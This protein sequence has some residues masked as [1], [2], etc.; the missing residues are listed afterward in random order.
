D[1]LTNNNK[2]IRDLLIEC[3]D[4]LDRNEFTCP[5]IDPNAAVPSS[6]VV[7]Y[8]CGLKMFK[9]LAY[10]FR[11]HMKQ[12]DVFPVIMRNRDNCYY[13]RKCRTQYTKIGH[14]QKLN[15]ACEQTKF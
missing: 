2:T 15:H 10:Q 6:K 8:K 12:D 14:A 4:R 7:C 1:Y 5:G 9:E 11:V 13:G 3:C